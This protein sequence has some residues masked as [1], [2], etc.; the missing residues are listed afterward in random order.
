MSAPSVLANWTFDV[1]VRISVI[2]S[3]V[4]TA[5]ENYLHIGSCRVNFSKTNP[6][7]SPIFVRIENLQPIIAY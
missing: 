1:K 4:R 6:T 2:Q 7:K 3:G 5:P